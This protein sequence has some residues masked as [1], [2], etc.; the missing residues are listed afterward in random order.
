[1]EAAAADWKTQIMFVVALV[2]NVVLVLVISGWRKAGKVSMWQIFLLFWL[3]DAL[4]PLAYQWLF[5]SPMA[6]PFAAL[7]GLLP[8]LVIAA[9]MALAYQREARATGTEREIA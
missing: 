1:M 9:S 6:L 2:I 8:A 4:V 3:V 7:I 5:T